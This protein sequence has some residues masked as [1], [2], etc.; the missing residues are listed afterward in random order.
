MYFPQVLKM[1]VWLLL[2]H[3]HQG[4]CPY[5]SSWQSMYL[6]EHRGTHLCM[7]ELF[8]AHYKPK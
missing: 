7:L 6:P 3:Q 8:T 2:T 5:Y 1:A 4:I